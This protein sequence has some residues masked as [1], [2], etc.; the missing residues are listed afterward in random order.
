M[1]QP[2]PTAAVVVPL[3]I[4]ALVLAVTIVTIMVM[5]KNK[6]KWKKVYP[7]TV[8]EEGEGSTGVAK[9][10]IPMTTIGGGKVA[11]GEGGGDGGSSHGSDV[12]LDMT[13]AYSFDVLVPQGEWQDLLYRGV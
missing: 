2:F 9:K 5:V 10:G 1:V 12:F 6:K 8:E 13:R 3:L 7:V 11:I 4:V